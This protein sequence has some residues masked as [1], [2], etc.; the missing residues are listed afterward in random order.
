MK[1]KTTFLMVAL[2]L[3]FGGSQLLA[4]AGGG[5]WGNGPGEFIDENGDGFNDLAPD[6]DGDGI[7]NHADED[8]VRP[9]NGQGPGSG[10]F[11][12]ENGDGYNDN[13]PDDDGDGIPNRYDEDFV[14]PQDGTGP[15]T[16][17]P[18]GNGNG[19]GQGGGGNVGGNGN[20]GGGNGPGPGDGTGPGGGDCIELPDPVQS[21]LRTNTAN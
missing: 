21:R 20:P 14:R 2:L 17:G 7:P 8:Y 18:G 12:D 11:V 4:Q 6:H 9:G 1:H 16:G 5:Q 10:E 3:A 15:G 19:G 13:A